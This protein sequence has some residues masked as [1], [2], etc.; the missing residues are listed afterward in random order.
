MRD[1]VLAGDGG[2]PQ[3][4]DEAPDE[5]EAEGVRKM[6]GWSKYLVIAAAGLLFL[7]D[8]LSTWLGVCVGGTGYEANGFTVAMSYIL[9]FPVYDALLISGFLTMLWYFGVRRDMLKWWAIVP[10]VV[11][12]FGMVVYNNVG[13]FFAPLPATEQVHAVLSSALVS[14]TDA[15]SFDR[16]LFCRGPFL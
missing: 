10:V 2:E 5:R 9:S 11:L 16:A 3:A 7:A 6:P 1:M 4:D 13:Q 12:L 15:P 8:G 14:H